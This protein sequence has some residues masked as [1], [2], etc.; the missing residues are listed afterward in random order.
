MWHPPWHGLPPA[1]AVHMAA[2]MEDGLPRMV[3]VCGPD[4][5]NESNSDGWTALHRSA[6]EGDAQR[7]RRL[8]TYGAHVSAPTSSGETPLELAQAGGHD[9]CLRELAVTATVASGASTQYPRNWTA[10]Q[11]AVSRAD[12]AAVRALLG[13]AAE[14]GATVVENL[15]CSPSPAAAGPAT[16]R[17]ADSPV[18]L[19]IKGGHHSILSELLQAAPGAAS[20]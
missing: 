2:G 17:K 16:T 4:S 8:L 18:C 9:A 7:V 15:V 12:A 6:A 3:A 11:L 13:A 14:Q 10:L 20:T 1:D 19:A 5:V